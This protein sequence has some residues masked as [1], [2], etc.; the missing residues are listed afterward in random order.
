MMRFAP[1]H[2]SIRRSEGFKEQNVVVRILA[3]GKA[4]EPDY[5]NECIR[6]FIPGNVRCHVES[7]GGEYRTLVGRDMC[8]GIAFVSARASAPIEPSVNRWLPGFC[9]CSGMTSRVP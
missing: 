4:T 5:F 7:G 8:A 3:E 2:P 1:R 6:G 9:M